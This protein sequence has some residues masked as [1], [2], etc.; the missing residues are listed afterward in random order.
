MCIIM[1]FLQYNAQLE[2][3]YVTQPLII[4]A[5]VQRFGVAVN[6]IIWYQWLIIGVGQEGGHIQTPAVSTVSYNK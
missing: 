5:P 4:V 6:P 2:W 3:A 1:Q